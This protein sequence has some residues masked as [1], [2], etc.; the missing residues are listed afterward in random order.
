MNGND[1]DTIVCQDKIN[2]S[3]ET[4]RRVWETLGEDRWEAK[5]RFGEIQGMRSNKNGKI[6]IYMDFNVKD[7]DTYGFDKVATLCGGMEVEA[8]KALKRNLKE[9]PLNLPQIRVNLRKYSLS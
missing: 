8:M 7:G 5:M 4:I 1:A 2:A 6:R 9:S 3:P